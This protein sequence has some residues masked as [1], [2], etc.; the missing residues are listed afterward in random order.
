MKTKLLIVFIVGGIFFSSCDVDRLPEDRI[1]DP[2][3]W[4]N[5]ND[6]KAAAD[7]LYTYLPGL[8]E[9]SDV[10]SDDAFGTQTNSI[11]D[12]SRI[13][14]GSDGYYGNQY[15]LIRAANNIIE[16]ASDVEELGAEP[17][18]VNW[19]VAEAR[20]YRAWAYFNLFRRY[21]EVPLILQT[22]EITDDQLYEGAA[23]REEIIAAIYADLDYGAQNLRKPSELP[24]EDYGRITSSA[25]LAFKSRVALFEGT[26]S[27]FHAYGN[28]EEHL[29]IARD[30]ALEVIESGEHSLHPDYFELFQY[31]GEGPQNTENILVRQ[32]GKNLE[33][34]ISSHASQ[35]NLETGAANPTKALADSYLYIDG[36]PIDESPLYSQ[37]EN[38]MDV[39][40]DRDP[41]MHATFF[42]EG[43]E[44][45]GTQPVFNLPQLSFQRTGFA[46]RRYA[47][48]D[49]WQ[50]S[51]SY[52]DRALIRYA[53]VLLNYAEATYE[54]NEEI[55]DEDLNISINVL[56]QRES[57]QMPLLANGFVNS[58][59]L[60]MQ[61]EIRR[62]RRV[63]LALEG[64]RY[65]DLIRWKTAEEE[66]PKPVLGN[67]FFEEF[68]TEVVPNT[69][70]NN[71]IL[72]Q[73]AENRN[74]DPSRDYLWPLPS[75]QL[76]LN[77]ALEQNPDW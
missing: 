32:Y 47:D 8:P 75:D 60:N 53:E 15:R 3:F 16:K 30:A 69:N 5:E 67:Y 28:P 50:V 18:R 76:G 6:L 54:L 72:L 17:E 22:L 36:L 66:L 26:R 51:R 14:P 41:R 74:F 44:Y 13:T 65:W 71:Q 21:G 2:A 10:W 42:K 48:I 73:E 1:S 38:T 49:D 33:E 31:E 46:N 29:T 58:A 23:S 11:S 43:D 27:K 4:Q 61:E 25:A 55:S 52:I 37:P 40:E 35:R 9:T 68:G 77:P 39:F 7:Y 24:S 19:Y 20:F 63:E 62:E 59:D 45:I 64:F 56:R 70:E 12:G 57:L 34:S